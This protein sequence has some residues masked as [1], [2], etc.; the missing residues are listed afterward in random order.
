MA[1]GRLEYLDMVKGVGIIGIVAMH[2][3]LLPVRAV[4]GISQMATPL[5]FLASG[6]LIAHTGEAEKDWRDVLK[7]K[8]RSLM[9]PFFWFS[10][11][12]ILRDLLRFLLG[13]CGGEEVL[14]VLRD[15]VTLF[16]SS[17]LWFLPTLF[18]AEIL[19]VFLLRKCSA[20]LSYL[21]C[22]ILTFVSYRGNELLLLRQLSGTFSAP[23]A[24]SVLLG[25]SFLRAAC[26]LPFLCFGHLLFERFRGFWEEDA[27]FC[28]W[29]TGG[30]ILLTGIGIFFNMRS[31]D[32]DFRGLYLGEKPIS[33]YLLA[34]V[35]FAGLV[36]VCKNCRPVRALV[37]FGQNSLIVMATHIGFYFLNVALKAA[38]PIH[39]FVLGRVGKVFYFA[40]TMG[41]VLLIEAVCIPVA[42]RFFPWL[43]GKNLRCKRQRAERKKL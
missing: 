40:G 29:Q 42:N 18:F 38:A 12:Y 7:K 11:L 43:L 27:R 17:V 37:Y 4:Y 21:I 14:G 33:A 10:L 35:F 30:G 24:L 19:F 2:S 31:A 9:L 32:M 23:A 41:V 28:L 20:P 16:G 3:T 1:K 25:Q 22:L 13:R 5:F 39:E 8:A 36:L 15:T 26:A 34:A 6:M